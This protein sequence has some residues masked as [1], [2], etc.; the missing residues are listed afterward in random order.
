M[1]KEKLTEEMVVEDYVIPDGMFVLT[2]DGIHDFL[3]KKTIR[4]LLEE[5]LDW[6]EKLSKIMNAARENGSHDDQSIIVVEYA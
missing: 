3:D 4:N 1:P 2:T 5:Q 6:E